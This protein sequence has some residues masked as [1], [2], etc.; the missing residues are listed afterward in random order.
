MTESNSAVGGVFGG[1]LYNSIV[2]Y[3]SRKRW[4][5]PHSRRFASEGRACEVA[6]RLECAAFPRFWCRGGPQNRNLFLHRR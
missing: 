4:N 5:A 6:K 2:Y 3:N 1:T